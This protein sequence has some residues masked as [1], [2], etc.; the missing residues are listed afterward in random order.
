MLPQRPLFLRSVAVPNVTIRFDPEPACAD[1]ITVPV[2]VP[3]SAVTVAMP[4]IVM[5]VTVAMPMIVMIVT[6]P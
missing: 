4:M 6:W 3:P 5:I 1:A 2:T